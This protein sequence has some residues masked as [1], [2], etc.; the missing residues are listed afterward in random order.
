MSPAKEA[1]RGQVPSAIRMLNL[2]SS[3]PRQSHPGLS[4]AAL[5]D[6][7]TGQRLHTGEVPVFQ[8]LCLLNFLPIFSLCSITDMTSGIKMH[9][10]VNF[11]NLDVSFI[12]LRNEAVILWCVIFFLPETKCLS[13]EGYQHVTENKWSSLTHQ[14]VSWSHPQKLG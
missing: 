4:H 2:F 3:D 8:G 10:Q 5:W 14:W 7:W 13:R 9:F 12:S 6:R 1:T 11:M